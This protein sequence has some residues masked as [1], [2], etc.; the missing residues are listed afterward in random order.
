MG[1]ARKK[2]ARGNRHSDEAAPV[3]DWTPP[4]EN[5]ATI[6]LTGSGLGPPGES[7]VWFG[8]QAADVL[9]FP[10]KKARKPRQ[11]ETRRKGRKQGDRRPGSA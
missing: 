9:S 3:L 4:A 7:G 2:P 5:G 10:Q 1:N 8:P 11:A 6:T